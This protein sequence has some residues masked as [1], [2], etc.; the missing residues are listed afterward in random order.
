M[1]E[2]NQKRLTGERALFAGYDLKIKVKEHLEKKGYEVI[3]E[4]AT[5]GT[6]PFSYVE[7]GQALAKDVLEGRRREVLLSEEQV[8]ESPSL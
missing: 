2:I 7:A 4:G 1:T 8:S 6:E 5:S 3:V